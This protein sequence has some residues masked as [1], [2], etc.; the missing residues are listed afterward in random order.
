MDFNSVTFGFMDH[1]QMDESHGTD[2]SD[3]YVYENLLGNLENFCVQPTD[4]NP[5]LHPWVVRKKQ[6]QINKFETE[7]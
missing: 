4:E 1:K 6:Q 3:N 5:D 7:I 2:G